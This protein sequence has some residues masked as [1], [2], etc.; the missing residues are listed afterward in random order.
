MGQTCPDMDGSLGGR[1][2]RS[3]D[4]YSALR[5]ER[6]ISL[7]FRK[8]LFD[9][10][11]DACAASDIDWDACHRED[12]GDGA[13]IVPSAGS[14]KVRLIYPLIHELAVQLKAYNRLA[15]ELTRIRVR[16]AI[17]AGEVHVD[18]GRM[19]G[20][21]LEFL[22][23]LLDAPVAR[24]ALAAAPPSVTVALIVS[25]HI[26]DEIIRHGYRG[27]DPDTFWQVRFTVKRTTASAWL[28]LP[29]YMP[30]LPLAVGKEPVGNEATGRATYQQNNSGH[31]VTA[32]QGTQNIYEG[33]RP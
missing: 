20:G 9:A 17:H 26:Y 1:S 5:G 19:A 8:V 14:P 31:N 15:S 23:R 22:A 3:E 10:L 32:N 29:G 6:A 12:L 33:E 28:H 2:N 25:E 4:P 13:R 21:P 18:D 7:Q 27:I 11:R 30:P 24:Q 16:A